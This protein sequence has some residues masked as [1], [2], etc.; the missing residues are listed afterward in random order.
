MSVSEQEL[1]DQL[2]LAKVL[3]S[4]V[5]CNFHKGRKCEFGMEAITR[6]GAHFT[7]CM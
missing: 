1:L 3:E 4:C 2:R 7:N 6:I 5:C